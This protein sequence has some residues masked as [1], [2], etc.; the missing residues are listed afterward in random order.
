MITSVN[1]EHAEQP[2]WLAIKPFGLSWMCGIEPSN[3]ARELPDLKIG[4][5]S[6]GWY[7]EEIDRYHELSSKLIADTAQNESDTTG[8]SEQNRNAEYIKLLAGFS[9][10]WS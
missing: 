9:K 3:L 2:E 8:E 7:Q 1:S 10:P 5:D 6:V 4:G